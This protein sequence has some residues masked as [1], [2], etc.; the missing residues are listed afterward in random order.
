MRFYNKATGE[1]YVYGDIVQEQYFS[2]GYTPAEF[3]EEMQSAD[4]L[5]LHINSYG[6]EIFAAI[7]IYNLIKQSGKEVEISVEGICASAATLLLCAGKA[8]AQRGATFMLH[9]PMVGLYDLYNLS[10]LEKVKSSLEAINSAVLEIYQSKLSLTEEEILNVLRSESWLTATQAKEL[11][12][13]DEVTE[14]ADDE[15]EK[16][17]PEMKSN[18]VMKCKAESAMAVAAKK[19]ATILEANLKSGAEG[20]GGSYEED[21]QLKQAQM[22]AKYA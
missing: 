9:L 1:I 2:S 14:G 20:V 13:I 18:Y 12:L 10:E 5:I 4:K 6:G 17:E 15:E 21:K 19:F 16:V 7:T 11:G 3:L 8:K 22:I